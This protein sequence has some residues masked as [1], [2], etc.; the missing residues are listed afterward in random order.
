MHCFEYP[1]Y[2]NIIP[3]KE[4]AEKIKEFASLRINKC[5]ITL[6]EDAVFKLIY[7]HADTIAEKLDGKEWPYGRLDDI[8]E[9]SF[10]DPNQTERLSFRRSELHSIYL[11]SIVL[12]KALKPLHIRED[13]YEGDGPNYAINDAISAGVAWLT[14]ALAYANKA[15]ANEIISHALIMRIDEP[16]I[17]NAYRGKN[18]PERPVTKAWKYFWPEEFGTTEET[19]KNVKKNKWHEKKKK[20]KVITLLNKKRKDIFNKASKKYGFNASDTI[21]I[22]YDLDYTEEYI[23]SPFEYD[24]IVTV[25]SK[26]KSYKKRETMSLPIWEAITDRSEINK[27]LCSQLEEI[28]MAVGS[29]QEVKE[30]QEEGKIIK[31][32]GQRAFAT[33]SILRI[34]CMS[35]GG[36]PKDLVKENFP[37]LYPNGDIKLSENMLYYYDHKM[38]YETFCIMRPPLIPPEKMVGEPL[39][40]YIAGLPLSSDTKIIQ[41]IE[42]K[43][44]GNEYLII[45]IKASPLVRIG[46]VFPDMEQDP[47]IAW[48]KAAQRSFNVL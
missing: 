13:Q 32:I 29:I 23:P 18:M 39:N 37:I 30:L 22:K 19:R 25:S 8:S 40:K 44:E 45:K 15:D 46:E 1:A 33:T 5:A 34:I 20:Q 36:I 28:I 3:K 42:L 10:S 48:N 41:V 12:R 4:L 17:Y 24:V 2:G 35:M 27:L 38:R 9:F 43:D 47:I 31:F 26:I 21:E 11:W 6:W 14:E 16:S 7:Q